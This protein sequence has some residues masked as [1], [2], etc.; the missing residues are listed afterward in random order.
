VRNY[1]VRFFKKICFNKYGMTAFPVRIS[2]P[3][4]NAV[5]V[6]L[7]L[8]PRRLALPFGDTRQISPFGESFL[9]SARTNHSVHSMDNLLSWFTGLKARCDLVIRPYPVNKM[10]EWRVTEDEIAHRDDKYFKISGIKV[11]I[12]NRKGVS[13][14]SALPRTGKT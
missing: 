1:G 8:N 7:L 6:F 14:R 2:A 4:N 12:A 5:L 10:T 9:L 13:R 3:L 11:S